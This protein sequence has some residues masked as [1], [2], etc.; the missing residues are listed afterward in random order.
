MPK[1][2]Q[3]GTI[4]FG[5]FVAICFEIVCGLRVA[6][7]PVVLSLIRKKAKSRYKYAVRTLKCQ[8]DRILSMKISFAL[9]GGRNR[10]FWQEIKRLKH[11]KTTK[12]SQSS[13]VDEFTNTQDIA[14]NFR[15]KLSNVLNFAEKDV[16]SFFFLQ[17]NSC[18]NRLFFDPI[19]VM[20][21]LEKLRHNEQDDS[22][23]SSNHL[24]LAASVLNEFLAM[25]FQS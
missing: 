13:I 23:L 21:A 12:P 17:D 22:Q 7:P 24:L 4:L 2:Y 15:C 10:D 25:F 20:K 8:K 18:T 6:A 16:V 3:N 5:I 19:T 1:S 11:S 14:N 9:T